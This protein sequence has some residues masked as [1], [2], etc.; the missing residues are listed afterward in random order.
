MDIEVAFTT[1]LVV[2]FAVIGWFAVYVVW[3]L[4][5]GQR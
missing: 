5:Q 4:F 3:K 1:L 2:V